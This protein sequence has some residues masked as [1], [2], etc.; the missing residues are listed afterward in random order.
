MSREIDRS[1]D[2]LSLSLFSGFLDMLI[3]DRNLVA[4]HKKG[5]AIEI[6]CQ[7]LWIPCLFSQGLYSCIAART[8]SD[9]DQVD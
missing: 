1:L 2:W 4:T 9:S 8:G 7:T 5:R 6:D 3:Q